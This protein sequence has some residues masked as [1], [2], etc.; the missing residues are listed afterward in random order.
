MQRKILSFILVVLA[1]SSL[2]FAR[3]R[4][5]RDANVETDKKITVIALTDFHGALETSLL[6]SKQGETVYLAGAEILSSYIKIIKQKKNI[7]VIIVDAGD[8]FQGTLISNT[9]EGK[10][11][12]SFYNYLGVSAVAVG[13]HDF[14]YGPVGPKSTPVEPGDDPQGALKIISKQSDFR[15]L[16]SNIENE[17]GGIPGWVRPSAMLTSGDIKVG[18]V[19]ASS[20]YTPRTTNPKNLSGLRFLDPVQSIVNEARN[21]KRK[22][23]DF[24]VV[25]V[26]EGTDCADNSQENIDD[27]STCR[28]GNLL[29]ILKKL[30]VGLVNVIVGGHTHKKAF[31]R[32]N[33]TYIMQP[34][35]K[36]QMVSWV[37]LSKKDTGSSVINSSEVCYTGIKHNGAYKCLEQSIRDLPWTVE[38]ATFLGEF[39]APDMNVRQLLAA[40]F[41]RVK[42]IKLRELGINVTGDVQRSYYDENGMGNLYT[43]FMKFIDPVADVALINNGGIRDNLFPGFLNYGH[44]YNTL[45]FDNVLA[46][47]ELYGAD[48]LRLIESGIQRTGGGN[49]WSGLTFRA[50]KCKVLEVMVNGKRLEM[51]RVYKIVSI[52]YLLTKLESLKLNIISSEIY[53][54]LILREVFFKNLKTFTGATIS[55]SNYIDSRNPRQVFDRLCR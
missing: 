38:R 3:D 41:E 43:D 44:I 46:R 2:S 18:V 26:H 12:V 14:D 29:G 20:K 49:S 35:A 33:G 17:S 31:K 47:Y 13:N 19:G 24:I 45:P 39:V 28:D 36:G 23:A 34:Y 52:D 4:Y 5:V 54:E 42:K 27:I 21:L 32:Y 37:D 6:T 48:L 1:V 22:G 9:G 55:P 15:F 8:M 11:V 40:D 30:P 25:M 53:D 16:A 50:D 51:D 10:P 7:P